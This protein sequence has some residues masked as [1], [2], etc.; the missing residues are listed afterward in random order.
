[1]S[2]VRPVL[3]EVWGLFVDDGNFALSI[4]AWLAVAI[5]GRYW[6]GGDRV[7]VGPVLALGLAA[8]LTENVAR[9]ARRGLK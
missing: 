3:R 7:W 2:W 4:V 5:A 9:S 1:M 6:L 8:I